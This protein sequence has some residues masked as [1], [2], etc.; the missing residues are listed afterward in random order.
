[1]TFTSWFCLY[2]G[3]AFG[4]AA[5]LML[6]GLFSRSRQADENRQQAEHN[7][8][9]IERSLRPPDLYLTTNKSEANAYLEKY[10]CRH[11]RIANVI[12]TPK[13]WSR[14][15]ERLGNASR[16]CFHVGYIDHA[17]ILFYAADLASF[18]LKI[19]CSTWTPE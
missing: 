9:R 13:A 8:D 11:W 4:T 10:I 18:R 7:Y 1:M 16:Y 12:G 5:G 6:S 17:E 3:L 14:T 15:I 2:S 19:E